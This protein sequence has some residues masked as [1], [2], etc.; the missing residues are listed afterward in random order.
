[1]LFRSLYFIED[2]QV[3]KNRH[4]R[5]SSPT[6]D[7]ASLTVPDKLKEILDGLVYNNLAQRKAAKSRESGPSTPIVD[8]VEF[9]FCQSEACVLRKRL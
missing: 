2:M 7:G 4:Y 1:M 6:C 5:K 3:A 9:L 8:S